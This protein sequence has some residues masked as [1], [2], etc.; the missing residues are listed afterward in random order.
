MMLKHWRVFTAA[1]FI[2]LLGASL[3]IGVWRLGNDYADFLKMREWVA[4]VQ[5]A[6]AQAEAAQRQQSKPPQ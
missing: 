6:Q 5:K 4:Q 3:A 1:F 2:G